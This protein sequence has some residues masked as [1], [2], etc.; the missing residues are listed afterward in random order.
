MRRV[1]SQKIEK[2]IM[3]SQMNR[4]GNIMY[5]GHQVVEYAD[6]VALIDRNQRN[7]QKK[8]QSI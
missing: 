2:I 3:Q 4:A 6:D 7:L 8:L 5:K 1:R